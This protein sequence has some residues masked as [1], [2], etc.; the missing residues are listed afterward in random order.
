[1]TDK[2]L[3]GKTLGKAFLKVRAIMCGVDDEAGVQ[4]VAD[5]LDGQ[6]RKEI[7]VEELVEEIKP[8][9]GPQG[10]F[11]SAEALL[12]R[13]EEAPDSLAGEHFAASARIAFEES[14]TL[15]DLLCDFVNRAV[16]T[17]RRRLELQV[18]YRNDVAAQR[19]FT[20]LEPEIRLALLAKN[21]A[22]CGLGPAVKSPPI[23]VK[24]QSDILKFE[25]VVT[26]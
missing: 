1:M 2:D 7:K 13:I 18:D 12:K 25:V 22:R 16:E 10:Y 4:A 19:A 5:Y 6:M 8:A 17:T 23:V 11:F 20:R 24:D 9:I 15:N 26:K 21:K 14:G 3:Y